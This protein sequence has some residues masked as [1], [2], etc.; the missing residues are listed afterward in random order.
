M[1][2]GQ[3]LPRLAM[4][5]RGEEVSIHLVIGIH[6]APGIDARMARRSACLDVPQS[7]RVRPA[8]GQVATGSQHLARV[9]QGLFGFACVDQVTRSAG[10]ASTPPLTPLRRLFVQASSSFVHICSYFVLQHLTYRSK[11]ACGALGQARSLATMRSCP[12]QRAKRRQQSAV[13]RRF[14][15]QRRGALLSLVRRYKCR[16]P[17]MATS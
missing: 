7:S 10:A 13:K 12:H 17:S 3:S 9:L 5:T 6:R 16:A 1:G 2:P 8:T 11:E 4:G 14:S 15:S